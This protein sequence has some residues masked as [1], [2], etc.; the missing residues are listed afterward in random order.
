[1]TTGG[2]SGLQ[3]TERRSAAESRDETKASDWPAGDQ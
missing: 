3:P 1:M 2:R